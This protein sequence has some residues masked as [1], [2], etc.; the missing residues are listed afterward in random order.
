MIHI[1]IEG[2]DR[3][4]KSTLINELAKDYNN[5]HIKHFSVPIGKT[6]KEKTIYQ[7]QSFAREFRFIARLRETWAEEKSAIA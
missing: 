4:G 1:I 6:N 2:I 7:K 5:V 3:L